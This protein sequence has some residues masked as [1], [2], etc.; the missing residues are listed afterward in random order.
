MLDE[1]DIEPLKGDL[2]CTHLNDLDCGQHPLHH[3]DDCRI[4]GYTNQIKITGSI[5][6]KR[7]ESRGVQAETMARKCLTPPILHSMRRC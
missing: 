4:M 2:P 1:V 5:R 6:T 7:L 3:R